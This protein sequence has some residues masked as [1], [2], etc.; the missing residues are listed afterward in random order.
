MPARAIRESTGAAGP[1]LAIPPSTSHDELRLTLMDAGRQV[2]A[3]VDD[4][5][6]FPAARDNLAR[7]CF[8]E[9]LPHLEGDE[10]WLLEARQCPELRLIADVIRTGARA[11]TAAVYELVAA[12]GPCEAVAATRVLHAFLAAH[13]HYEQLLHNRSVDV[14]VDQS[15]LM[16]Q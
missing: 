7:F 13:A 4:L 2:R 15:R 3:T 14:G 5:D 9:L 16:S 8:A 1:C 11:M 6:R 12:T 10:S